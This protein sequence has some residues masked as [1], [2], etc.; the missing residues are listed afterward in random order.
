ML[1]CGAL[2]VKLALGATWLLCAGSHMVASSA[3]VSEGTKAGF[4]KHCIIV[5]SVFACSKRILPIAVFHLV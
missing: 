5:L 1:G 2:S 4:T 3:Q